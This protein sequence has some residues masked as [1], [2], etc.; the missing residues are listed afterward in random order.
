MPASAVEKLL[1]FILLIVLVGAVIL[2]GYL[3]T[4]PEKKDPYTEF[5]ML[6]E[7]GIAED[8]VY[9]LN[10]GQPNSVILG[11]TNHEKRPVT[12]TIEVALAN[13]VVNP[14]TNVT[15]IKSAKQIDSFTVN[16]PD[17]STYEQPYTFTVNQQGYNKLEFLLFNE[18][19]PAPT[20]S[21]MDRINAAY[22]NVNLWIKVNLF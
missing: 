6:G 13:E 16:V 1:T 2:A 21:G 4:L 7:N 14:T 15:T 22:R 17:G 12:Y 18:T 8:Y 9:D 10:I 19:V 5:Y 20:V 3:S 11:V